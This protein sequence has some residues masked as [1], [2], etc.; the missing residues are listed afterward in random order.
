MIFSRFRACVVVLVMTLFMMLCATGN[1]LTAQP[2]TALPL[3]SRCSNAV[4]V[5]QSEIIQSRTDTASFRLTENIPATLCYPTTANLSLIQSGKWYKVRIYRSG[6]LGF[7]LRP[8]T[9]QGRTD[10]AANYDWAVFRLSDSAKCGS[11]ASPILCN[12]STRGGITGAA[13]IVEDEMGQQNP[14]YS[15]TIPNV[16]KGEEY[17]LLVLNPNNHQTGYSL[18]FGFS[19]SPDVVIQP[20]IQVLSLTTPPTMCQTNSVT[21]RFSDLVD[22]SSLTPAHFRLESERGVARAITGISAQRFGIIASAIEDAFDSVFT[23][24]FA[25]PISQTETYKLRVL[26][27]IPSL[28]S[29]VPEG[30]TTASVISVGPRVEIRGLR[31]YCSGAG[32]RLTASSDKFTAYLWS[33]LNTGRIHSTGSTAILP[34]GDYKLSVIDANGCMGESVATVRST[35]AVALVLSATNSRNEAT[36]RFCNFP[37]QRDYLLLQAT[38][39]FDRYEWLVNGV[40]TTGTVSEFYVFGAPG[41]YQ[42]RA[43][44]NGC[45]AESNVLNVQMQPIPAKPQIRQIGNYLSVVN[46]VEAQERYYWVRVN[47]NGS[48]TGQEA[49][50]EFSPSQSGVYLVQARNIEGCTL[51]SDTLTFTLT[52]VRVRL[53][54]GSYQANHNRL[55]DI[56]FTLTNITKSLTEIGSTSVNFTLRMDSRVLG[57]SPALQRGIVFQVNSTTTFVRTVNCSWSAALSNNAASGTIGTLRMLGTLHPNTAVTPLVLENAFATTPIGKRLSGITFD[58]ETGAIFRIANIPTGY[59]GTTATLESLPDGEQVN[60]ISSV[61]T[62]PNPIVNDLVLSLSLSVETPVNAWIQDSF[63]NLVKR[64]T[65]QGTASG[66]EIFA[67]GEH[68]RTFSLAD[69]REGMYVLVVQTPA[70]THSSLL[71]IRR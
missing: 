38:P 20:N 37:D 44:A 46:R 2:N 33:N 3:G 22:V 34:E 65:V 21:V 12:T 69:V 57:P 6:T 7:A 11:L 32:A 1:N 47:R 28:C 63:G 42:V 39:E 16:R 64:L 27:D 53:A 17:L 49:G 24:Q 51:E 35:N 14:A 4:L 8:L 25:D 19:S 15:E 41:R 66:A 5:C 55:F 30:A 50:W 31:A 56:R 26:R 10:A 61:K 40:V 59:M 48:L 23:L 13:G 68:E 36:T 52:P 18:D 60:I 54:T 43:F 45:M 58:L 29:I 71:S 67:I 62:F 70:K 9:A